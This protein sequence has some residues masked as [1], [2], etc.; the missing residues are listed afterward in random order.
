[1]GQIC[2]AVAGWGGSRQRGMSLGG[3]E[4]GRRR[5]GVCH[6]LPADRKVSELGHFPLAGPLLIPTTFF[7]S[8]EARVKGCC[9]AVEVQIKG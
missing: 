2:V 1:M 7:Y 9:R 5:G 4:R 8:G 6:V 3:G